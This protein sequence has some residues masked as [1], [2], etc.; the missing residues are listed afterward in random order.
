[1]KFI[2][3]PSRILATIL[4]LAHGAAAAL[5]LLVGMAPWLEVITI[6]ALAASLLFN[7]RK[8]ALLRARDAVGALE[9]TSD[10]KLSVQDRRGEWIVCAVRG[11][12]YVTFFLVILNLRA[13]DSGRNMHAV[14]LPDSLS[15]D[16]FRNLRVWLRFKREPQPR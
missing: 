15:A 9:I 11:S 10:G 4:V 5:I 8:S 12:S 7:L 16:D 14:I 2:L 3:R 1:M 6:A 13:L